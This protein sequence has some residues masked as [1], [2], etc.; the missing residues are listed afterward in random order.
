MWK[1]KKINILLQLL[2]T[3]PHCAWHLE[4]SFFSLAL[5]HNWLV[6]IR[7]IS[8]DCL[9]DIA[10][11]WNLKLLFQRFFGGFYYLF[12]KK[13]NLHNGLKWFLKG[14]SHIFTRYLWKNNLN[15]KKPG[16]VG[17]NPS[18]RRSPAIYEWGKFLTFKFHEFLSKSPLGGIKIFF[19]KCWNKNA[20]NLRS[21]K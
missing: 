13:L 1:G 11:C 17:I 18:V 5:Y 4:S 19:C 21:K 2:K 9:T 7:D 10:S 15:P 6:H 8:Q 20:K 3:L 16:G 14:L 12:V